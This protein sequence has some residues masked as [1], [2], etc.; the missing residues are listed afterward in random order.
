MHQQKQQ[1]QIIAKNADNGAGNGAQIPKKKRNRHRNSESKDASAQ[2][3]WPKR[4]V[5]YQ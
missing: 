1:Q 5:W 3:Q 4:K 2:P